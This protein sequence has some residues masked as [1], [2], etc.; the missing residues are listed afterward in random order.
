MPMRCL[1]FIK[2]KN[3]QIRRCKRQGNRFFCDDH[4]R[5]PLGWLIFLL[6]SA[7]GVVGSIASILSLFGYSR[8]PV[9]ERKDLIPSE[10][11]FAPPVS[12]PQVPPSPNESPTP[13]V[14]PTLAPTPS[15]TQAVNLSPQKRQSAQKTETASDHIN[16]ARALLGREQLDAAL[17]EC[18]RALRLEPK[19]QTAIELKNSIYDLYKLRKQKQ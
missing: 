8:A 14:A 12:N 19:N 15:P 18:N 16:R 9:A 4:S 17:A 13:K 3:F 6:V 2:N 7:L 11:N 1:G 5:Q 10:T